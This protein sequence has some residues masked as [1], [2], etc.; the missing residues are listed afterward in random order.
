MALKMLIHPDY[1]KGYFGVSRWLLQSWKPSGVRIAYVCDIIPAT[2][3][4]LLVGVGLLVNV[5]PKIFGNESPTTK[6]PCSMAE[7]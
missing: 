1:A 3:R 5:T 4:T 7:N 6:V 2:D